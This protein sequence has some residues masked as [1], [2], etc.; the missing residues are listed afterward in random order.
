[1]IKQNLVSPYGPNIVGEFKRL[2]QMKDCDIIVESRA[3]Q[4]AWRVNGATHDGPVLNEI[5]TK[6]KTVLYRY[7]VC[8]AN[9]F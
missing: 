4:D 2:I 9:N 5:K 3:V 8:G 7:Q 6:T 1:M